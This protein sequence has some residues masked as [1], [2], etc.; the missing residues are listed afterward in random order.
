MIFNKTIKLKDG[1]DCLLRNEEPQDAK[2]FYRYFKQAHS[3]TDFLTTYPDEVAEDIEKFEK[4]AQEMISS[5]TDIEICAFV[6]GVLVGS[7]G[8][9]LIGRKDKLKHRAEFGI[10]VIKEYW[11]LG[12]GDALT[13]E[14][15]KCA[16]DAGLLQ[17]EL[18]VVADNINAIKLYEKYGFEEYGRNPRGFKNREGK[19]QELVLMRLELDK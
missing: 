1:R 9:N 15:I 3:E 5:P 19:W 8:N 12:I 11:G 6:D 18:D 13:G 4:D 17:L 16:K 7:A 10:S 2:E 14:C